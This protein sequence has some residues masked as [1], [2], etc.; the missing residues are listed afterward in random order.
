MALIEEVRE[1]DGESESQTA[2][3]V[4]VARGKAG[5]GMRER[6][7]SDTLEG[8][9][10]GGK[11]EVGRTV[12]RGLRRGQQNARN[13]AG[14]QNED[15]DKPCLHQAAISPVTIKIIGYLDWKTTGRAG[16]LRIVVCIH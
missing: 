15:R 10:G 13:T 14:T 11:G 3:E 1:R 9:V 16:C 7:E 2:R 5:K 12:V 4:R 8:E 6:T